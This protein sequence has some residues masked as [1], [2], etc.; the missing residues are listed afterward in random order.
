MRATPLKKITAANPIAACFLVLLVVATLTGIE[1]ASAEERILSFHSD[2]D[3]YADGT[4]MVTETIRVV[5]ERKQIKRGIYRDFPTRYKTPRGDN[6]VVDFD[7]LHVSRN[8]TSEAHHIQTISNGIRIY[9]GN[10]DVILSPGEYEYQLTYH[11]NRQ[12][13]FFDDHDELYW[14]V[15]GN[16]W[17]FP[18]N[19]ASARVK[20]P[21][22]VL[23]DEILVEAY[24]GSRGSRGRDYTAEVLG[25]GPAVFSTTR[26][27]RAGEGLTLVASWPKGHIEEP[28]I[29]DKAGYF[30]R[31][32][33]VA[34]IS[35]FGLG[36]LLSYYLI[37]WLKVGRDPET[38]TIVPLFHPPD[39][40]SPAAMRYVYRMGFDNK[41]YSAA[42][43]NMA[44]K[45]YLTIEDHDKTYELIRAEGADKSMLSRGET[46]IA[47]SLLGTTN[48]ITLEQTNNKSIR[49]SVNALK[50]LLKKEYHSVQFH[51]NSLYLIPGAILSLI[52]LVIAGFS[53]SGEAA[54]TIMMMSVCSIK[55]KRVVGTRSVRRD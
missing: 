21:P 47:A 52:I 55:R 50:A 10:K 29:S 26:T 17:A 44:V 45:G 33:R 53:Y 4:M 40:L 8:G 30:L 43:L 24:T 22:T 9:I 2:I 12:L 20:L 27:L 18:I 39:N 37:V 5:A 3:V 31:D 7:L 54:A 48:S 38:G 32:N 41:A 11:T 35:L 49:K 19:K 13:G 51:T 23:V 6:Y 46:K 42:L 1:F 36:A 14:N 16:E 25:T 28:S 34:V 15:T